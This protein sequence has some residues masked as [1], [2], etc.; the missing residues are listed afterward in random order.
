ME[1]ATGATVPN[2][3]TKCQKNDRD[4]KGNMEGHV[5]E[6]DT[7]GSFN[8][9]QFYGNISWC[10]DINGEEIPGTKMEVDERVTPCPLHEG[11]EPE[12]TCPDGV[13]S[14]P[15]KSKT[16]CN[17]Y[18]NCANGNRWTQFCPYTL[19]FDPEISA[20]NWLNAV[21]SPITP[22]TVKMSDE[23]QTICC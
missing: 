4:Q 9:E 10:V 14:K 7:D 2:T 3:L 15:I 8:R 5:S 11:P 19:V 20:C 21:C 6:C 18:Y 17:K 12:T 1:K 16:D 13:H 22:R 23:F